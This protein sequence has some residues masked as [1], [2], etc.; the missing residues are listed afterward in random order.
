M[1]NR[2]FFI[3]KIPLEEYVEG[4]VVKVQ[5][6]MSLNIGDLPDFK[7]NIFVQCILTF[8]VKMAECIVLVCILY[9]CLK[10][11]LPFA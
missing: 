8:S 9:S 5:G 3:N 1:W 11:K 6:R 7:T 10:C 2:G 4:S